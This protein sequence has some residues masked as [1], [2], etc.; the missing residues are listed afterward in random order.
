MS[1]E[2]YFVLLNL[3]ERLERR[4]RSRSRSPYYDRYSRRSRSRSYSPPR[5]YRDEI[6]RD[7]LPPR[8]LSPE[9]LR[10]TSRPV[11]FAIQNHITD[12][13]K[14]ISDISVDESQEGAAE[15]A[16]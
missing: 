6:R 2:C 8:R 1:N 5:R 3:L 10:K 4:R 7:R 9:P 13:D 16:P 12:N 14:T 15:P 11:R